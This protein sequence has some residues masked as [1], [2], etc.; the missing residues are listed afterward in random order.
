[1]AQIQEGQHMSPQHSL[2]PREAHGG[3]SKVAKQQ[4]TSFVS[5]LT[6]YVELLVDLTIAKAVNRE[7][8]ET[9]EI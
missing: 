7:R 1:M 4:V 6:E 9:S 3:I 2:F 5:E 8:K